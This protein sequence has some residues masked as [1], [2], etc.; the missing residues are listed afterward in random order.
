[1]NKVKRK[2]WIDKWY[3]TEP[4][5]TVINYDWAT[6]Y[7]LKS[8]ELIL[9]EE[10]ELSIHRGGLI[11][12]FIRLDKESL[13]SPLEEVTDFNHKSSIDIY[14]I[15]GI[16]SKYESFK[17]LELLPIEPNYG[18]AIIAK[19]LID[20]GL[21]NDFLNSL[22]FK[23]LEF[24]TQGEIVN[25]LSTKTDDI[26]LVVKLYKICQKSEAYSV[27]ESTAISRMANRLIREE[28]INF[29]TAIKMLKDTE[30]YNDP[31]LGII[32]SGFA[33]NGKIQS[34]RRCLDLMES[35]DRLKWN[36]LF[37][38]KTSYI[39]LNSKSQDEF[40]EVLKSVKHSQEA[41]M[42]HTLFKDFL[43]PELTVNQELLDFYHKH[44]RKQVDDTIHN[45][46]LSK[47]RYKDCVLFVD[48]VQGHNRYSHYEQSFRGL[49]EQREYEYCINKSKEIKSNDVRLTII[50]E[51]LKKGEIEIAIRAK[52]EIL[53]STNYRNMSNGS[54]IE[55][56]ARNSDRK[57]LD[58]LIERDKSTI[59]RAMKYHSVG[60]YYMGI[61]F[62]KHE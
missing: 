11:R 25:L 23:E 9:N 58:K 57:N 15:R 48:A 33:Q 54:F 46:L 30:I 39:N 51:L 32:A 27:A 61:E 52:K 19:R 21:S 4:N 56:Y 18:N 13:I 22:D 37:N 38:A 50:D 14:K 34:Y 55:Y 35:K 36:V 28:K 31:S 12:D 43:R 49:L 26:N 53:K 45:Y 3:H 59:S 29:E 42:F 1:M 40:L 41:K 8:K 17:L 10:K 24:S 5:K 62:R 7:L 60:R 47:K 6:E 44:K 16:A 2:Y 20:E